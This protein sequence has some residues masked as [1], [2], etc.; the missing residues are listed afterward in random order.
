M[1]ALVAGTALFISTRRIEIVGLVVVA[2]LIINALIDSYWVLE[3]IGAGIAG[4]IVIGVSVEK[5]AGLRLLSFP[6]NADVK[7][8][9]IAARPF[10]LL[11]VAID[12]IWDRRIVLV[13]IGVLAL[14]FIV[15][16]LVRLFSKAE[17]GAIFKR[18]EAK[19][20]SSMTLFL[21]ATFLTFLLFPDGISYIAL[22]C[23]TV[24]DFFSKLL[25]MRYGRRLLYRK[26][27]LEGS[28]GFLAGSLTAS[29]CIA[30]LVDVPILF[31]LIGAGVATIVELFSERI[32]D[33]FTVS[34]VTG[35]FLTA[36]RFFTGV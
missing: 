22:A 1:I 4:I 14:I 17:I 19:R 21:V 26:K 6:D 34:I 27:T 30:V 36:I 11:F 16:D 23:I 12:V 24:G 32:D 28:L 3:T 7:V 35:G 10:A 29:Y 25:G 8:W 2:F 15:T 5:I 20:F 31:V 33:N 9:R 13:V 18:K